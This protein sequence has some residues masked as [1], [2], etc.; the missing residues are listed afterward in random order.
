MLFS[1][2][3]ITGEESRR[4]PSTGLMSGRSKQSDK[5]IIW[6]G[7]PVSFSFLLSVTYLRKICFDHIKEN[8]IVTESEKIIIRRATTRK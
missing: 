2:G 6:T 7:F 4:L 8:C 5:R 1:I 3:E